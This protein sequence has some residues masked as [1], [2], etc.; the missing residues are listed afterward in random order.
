MSNKV[1]FRDY[2]SEDK[3]A[4]IYK[5]S[6][7]S[8]SDNIYSY[9]REMVKSGKLELP[10]NI[11]THD[12]RFIGEFRKLVNGEDKDIKEVK[13]VVNMFENG[14]VK[15]IMI[16]SIL[17][18]K[19]ESKIKESYENFIKLI[20]DGT[21]LGGEL[22]ADDSC[23]MC[24]QRIAVV[25]KDWV[26]KLATLKGGLK[27]LEPCLEEKERELKV[28]FTSGE[29]LVADWI[30][31]KE[32]SDKVEYNK[33]YQDVGL[34]S[35]LGQKKSTEH[36]GKF[37]FITV[38]VGNSSPQIYQNGDNLLFGY[39]EIDMNDYKKVGNVCTDLWNA[40]VIDKERLIEIIAEKIG[41]EEAIDKV[42]R[43]LK[44]NEV[45]I[46]RVT[47]GEYTLRYK[48]GN[49]LKKEIDEIKE[50]GIDEEVSVY[51]SLKKEGLKNKL[52]MK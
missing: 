21:F 30:R 23:V 20:N 34:G 6:L 47:P 37:G 41:E 1:D 25:M 24:G 31:I 9:L 7:V 2:L 11:E 52:K 43:Y 35:A 42:E 40:T 38:H 45:N 19:E 29:L 12:S 22:N 15:D 46:I 28:N 13:R 48:Y 39:S 36:A 5:D 8:F 14:W 33:D 16:N 49:S 50:E 4:E 44:K 18:N 17:G 32:F 3:Y 10:S 27:V 26:V 51:F